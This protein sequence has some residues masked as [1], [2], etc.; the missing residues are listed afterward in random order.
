LGG[1]LQSSIESEGFRWCDTE[2]LE[3][4]NV[5]PDSCL[6]AEDAWADQEAAFVR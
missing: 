5:I 6:N 4:I 3:E 2:D 1:A